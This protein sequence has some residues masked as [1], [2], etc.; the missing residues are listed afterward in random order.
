MAIHYPFWLGG[1]AASMAACC[2]HPLDLTKVRMQ[3]LKPVEGAK[4]STF[5]V[6]RASVTESGLR[7]LY[8]GLRSYEEIKSRMSRHGK[9]TTPQLLLA[10]SFAGALGGI[11]GNS[12]DI[13]L[14]RMTSDPIKPPEK[15][16]NYSNAITGLIS[17]IK[18]EG[19]KGLARGIGPNT[20]RAI[21]MTA[22]QVGSYDYFKS[23]LL[24]KQIPF[25]N[26]QLR[27]SLLLHSIA[28]CLA[29]TLATTVCSPVD[30]LRSR[31]MSSS[32]NYSAIQILKRS[33]EM[34]GP[35]FLFKGWTPAFIRLGPNTVLLFVF[36][37]QLKK[38][39][40][41]LRS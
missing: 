37:E 33:L 35:K 23:V 13:L 29:G 28:S 36:F 9:P 24:N 32:S 22:S 14:V 4:H 15:R 20:A 40:N 26:Y 19:V 7:S 11:A 2:T 1:V 30:V 5:S 3:T 12:A 10:A 31:V 18:E 17:L 8:T 27:D 16:Y 41:T 39:W 25:T 38:G 6:I 34:E 21:L